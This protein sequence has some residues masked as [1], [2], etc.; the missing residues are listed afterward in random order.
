MLGEGSQPLLTGNTLDYYIEGLSAV[1][2]ATL[3]KLQE[4]DDA[5]LYEERSWPN[6]TAYNMYYLWFHVLED[7]ISHRG[8]I[9]AAMRRLSEGGG[10][11]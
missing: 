1:R 2:E 10:L 6:G 3:Q 5:W 7:E 4:K 8:Q 11:S 9:R